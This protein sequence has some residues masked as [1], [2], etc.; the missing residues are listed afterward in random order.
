MKIL[1]C[2]AILPVL[3]SG[4]MLPD[5][6]GSHTR[7]PPQNPPVAEPHDPVWAELGL[8]QMEQGDYGPNFTVSAF[9]LPDTTA[10]LAAFYW[11][12]PASSKPSKAA[13][14]AAETSGELLLTV[15]NY[16][17]DFRGYKPSGAEIASLA[18]GLG[19]TD[20][21]PL[22]PNYLP[23]FDMVPNSERY[24]TGPAALHAFLPAIP[25]GVV[26]FQYGAEV[27]SAVFHNSQGDITVA[28][29]NYPT[30]QIA[31]KQ[32]AGF[33]QAGFMTKRSGPLVSVVPG[34]P[35]DRSFAQ[36]LLDGVEFRAQVTVPEHIYTLRDNIGNLVINAFILIGILLAITLAA[37]LFVGGFRIYQRRGGRDPDANTV[38]SLHLE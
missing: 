27:E 28:I 18:Q 16:L 4:A 15:G 6:I 8:Q 30:P 1:V 31:M 19:K 11:L 10:S 22:P 21:T 17:I 34:T 25:A 14:L 35:A 5:A 33:E 38:I 9:R 12:R 24:S 3:A 36:M 23:P 13:P 20:H 2:L 32:A 26:G 37:G 7:R 29:F